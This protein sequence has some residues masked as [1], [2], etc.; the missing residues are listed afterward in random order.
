MFVAASC[1]LKS[2]ME[3]AKRDTVALE[4]KF[5]AR[6]ATSFFIRTINVSLKNIK[7]DTQ[8][9]FQHDFLAKLL[10]FGPKKITQNLEK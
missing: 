10:H 8:F 1:G 3:G 6:A 9:I 7:M 2:L 5:R 4:T